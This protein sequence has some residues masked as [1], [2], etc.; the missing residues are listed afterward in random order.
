MTMIVRFGQTDQE[1]PEVDGDVDHLLEV[2]QDEDHVSIADMIGQRALGADRPRDGVDR[3]R[4]F[5]DR[6]QP[7]PEHAGAMTGHESGRELDRETGLSGPAGADQRQQSSTLGQP[8]PGFC[9]F[10]LPPDEGADGIWE[11]RAR[12]GSQWRERTSAQLEEGQRL[13]DV[14][15][16]MGAEVLERLRRPD[17]ARVASETTTWP[18]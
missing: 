6:R 18:P 17:S 9:Q 1:S 3:E 12:N 11:V 13:G 2:V 4:R 5:A 10:A 8:G 16:A 7:D 15:Q 14:L